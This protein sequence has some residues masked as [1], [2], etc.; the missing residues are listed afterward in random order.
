MERVNF[1]DYKLSEEI[2]KA[3]AGLKYENPT[4]V[5]ARVIPIALQNRDLV[6]QSQTGSGK[7]AAFGIP[8]CDMI[9]WEENRPQAL[10]LTPT[11]EL[12]VQVKDDLMSIGRFKRIKVAAVFGKQPFSEQQRELKLKTHI[13]TGTPGRVFDHISR[14]TL[15]LDKIRYLI[16]DE[17]DEMFNMGFI[18]QVENI[19]N[20][21]PENRVTMLFSATL[22]E[23]V[24]DLCSKYIKNPVRIDMETHNITTDTISHF[25][26]RVDEN[27][28]FSLLK[29]ITVTENPDSCIIF[30]S[31][32]DK[33]DEIFKKLRDTGYPCEKLHGGMMQEDRL[34]VM[35][36]FKS[37]KFIYLVATDVAARGIDVSDVTH[38]INYDIPPE[39]ESYVHRTGRTGRAGK[40]GKAISFVT[41]Y[42]DRFL[43][44]I[45]SYI[46]FKITELNAPEK[47]QILDKKEAFDKKI[48]AKPN[49][50]KDKSYALN[51][52]I[53]KLY[54][55][56]GRKKKIRAL[57]FV[58][59]I[60]SI[61][62][63]NADD[64]GIIDIQDNVSYVDI[65]N[66]KGNIVLDAMQNTTIK[67]KKLKVEKAYK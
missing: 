1:K 66:G 32:K 60:T 31:T 35:K 21:L 61:D 34:K 50:K 39:T 36:N 8:I 6:V 38:I 23:E 14:N 59:T 44:D 12:A 52:D 10:I 26:Y 67:G 37:G 25:F 56:G 17:A 47:E 30:C 54:F 53:M 28:K 29:D 49:I 20:K 65:L 63:I 41:P 46:G 45:E 51:K 57:D 33:T 4:E 16:I 64:I 43:N 24:E 62:G 40:T 22:P 11:R 2:L 9:D 48:S 58:G 13:V 5:Q 55:N 19:I 27:H 7:T 15:P 3:L 42:E 18:E